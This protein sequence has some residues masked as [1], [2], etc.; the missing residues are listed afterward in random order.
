M[1]PPALIPIIPLQRMATK[2][3]VQWRSD[4]GLHLFSLSSFYLSIPHPLLLSYGSCLE[5]DK[6]V[7]ISSQKMYVNSL[8]WSSVLLRLIASDWPLGRLWWRERWNGEME[9]GGVEGG[10]S[11]GWAL[12]RPQGSWHLCEIKRIGQQREK[13][14]ENEAEMM[15]DTCLKYCVSWPMLWEVTFKSNPLRYCVTSLK[16]N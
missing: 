7:L 16:W 9:K 13:I 10:D 8:L 4:P 15:R 1:K 5:D 12:M 2:H 11:R 6:T 3:T 14:R